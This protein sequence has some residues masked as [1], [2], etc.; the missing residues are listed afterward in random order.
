M[1]R[2]ARQATVCGIAESDTTVQLTFKSILTPNQGTTHLSSPHCSPPP[3][4]LASTCG[5]SPNTQVRPLTKAFA[6]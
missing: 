6:A 2:G 5:S 1:D 3:P 4:A